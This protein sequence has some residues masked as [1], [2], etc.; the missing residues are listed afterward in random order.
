[1]L[2]TPGARPLRPARMLSENMAD[3][4]HSYRASR[5]LAPIMTPC[6]A[7]SIKDVGRANRLAEAPL[8]NHGADVQQAFQRPFAGHPRPEFV[9][10]V[11]RPH[12]ALLEVDP[13]DLGH[14]QQST[15]GRGAPE[16]RERAEADRPVGARADG[17]GVGLEPPPRLACAG[18]AA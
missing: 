9:E 6:L 13:Q 15:N 12:E 5:R 4:S 10:R 11:S 17:W 8:M 14:Q 3:G 16:E 1:M 18:A 7:R 2:S